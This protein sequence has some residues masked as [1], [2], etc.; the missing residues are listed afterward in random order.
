MLVFFAFIGFDII[1]TLADEAKEPAKNV[2]SS[3]MATLAF[4]TFSYILVSVALSG[5]T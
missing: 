2:P 1:N 4:C 5:M 3:V